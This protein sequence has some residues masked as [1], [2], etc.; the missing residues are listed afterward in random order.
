MLSKS[1]S[2]S[3]LNLLHTIIQFLIVGVIKSG[4]V[5]GNICAYV[6]GGGTGSGGT[7]GTTTDDSNGNNSPPKPPS[8]AGSTTTPT[9]STTTVRPA[10]VDPKSKN[11]SVYGY[12]ADVLQPTKYYNKNIDNPIVLFAMTYGTPYQINPEKDDDLKSFLGNDTGK[13]YIYG[14]KSFLPES[15]NDVLKREACRRA[16]LVGKAKPKCSNW[17]KPALVKYL[18]ENLPPENE[19]IAITAQTTD[20]LRHLQDRAK[21]ATNARLFYNLR[22]THA[23]L[24]PSIRDLMVTRDDQLSR[25]D[26]D[27]GKGKKL[28]EN[29]ERAAELCNG[30]TVYHSIVLADLGSP[31]DQVNALLPDKTKK[32]DAKDMKKHLADLKNGICTVSSHCNFIFSSLIPSY[33]C[34][35]L[36]IFLCLYFL[37]LSCHTHQLTAN[38]TKSGNGEGNR[39]NAGRSIEEDADLETVDDNDL[40]TFV[41]N[42][43]LALEV[44]YEFRLVSSVDPNL[45]ENIK[46]MLNS[47]AAATMENLPSVCVHSH[48]MIDDLSI[49]FSHQ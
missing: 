36:T 5:G 30:D 22:K 8:T 43:S 45:A 16:K 38:Y 17:G 28:H 3:Y 31:Y 20:L 24:D 26:I 33:Y 41:L 13:S 47:T 37:T 6:G 27:E 34:A 2:K 12:D 40:K 19:R 7:T 29:Y 35:K 25:K 4:F 49:S 18:K 1:N 14:K 15:N 32:V 11:L 42:G 10:E 46:S 48:C 39:G 44:I 23:L 9:E 21:Q